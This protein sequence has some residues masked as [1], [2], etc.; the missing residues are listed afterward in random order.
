MSPSAA[1]NAA[2]AASEFKPVSADKMRTARARNLVFRVCTLVIRLPVTYPSFASDAVDNMFSTI[3]CAV[4]AFKRVEPATTSGPTT[5]T[6]LISAALVIGL[7][8]THV[9]ATVSAP[10]ER[11]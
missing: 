10:N 9:R 1:S 3:F 2:V 7:F 4:P 5:G 6:M 8:G 11:A